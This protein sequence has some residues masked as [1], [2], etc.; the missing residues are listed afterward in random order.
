MEV[1][2]EIQKCHQEIITKVNI[3]I[4]QMNN[5]IKTLKNEKK[6]YVRSSRGLKILCK[7]KIGPIIVSKSDNEGITIGKLIKNKEPKVEGTIQGKQ[8][9]SCNL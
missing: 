6:H 8:H 2:K 4:T 1:E 7:L 5:E 9:S 3:E